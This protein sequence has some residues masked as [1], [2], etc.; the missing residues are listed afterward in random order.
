[1]NNFKYKISLKKAIANLKVLGSD[2]D[3]DWKIILSLSII[4][5]IVSAVFH[6]SMLL[7]TWNLEKL[8]GGESESKTELINTK[9]LNHVL[10]SYD[11]RAKEFERLESASFS[12][13]DPAR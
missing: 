8:S 3:K 7:S 1:M 6:F 12:F 11:D 9:K 13:T 4:L 2:A 5:V 10:E